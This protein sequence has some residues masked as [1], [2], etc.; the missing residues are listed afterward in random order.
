MFNEHI[1][2]KNYPIAL[3]T[4]D[5]QLAILESV[6]NEASKLV[7]AISRLEREIEF[8]REYRTRL[9]ADVVTSKLDVRVAAVRLPDGAE[10]EN[11]GEAGDMSE[12]DGLSDESEFMEEESAA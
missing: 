9:V 3:P 11:A 4:I 2:I 7:T 8:L 10:G 12:L 1:F 5:E 6:H